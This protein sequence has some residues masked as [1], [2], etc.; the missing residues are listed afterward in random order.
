MQ[1]EPE[2]DKVP[3]RAVVQGRTMLGGPGKFDFDCSEGHILAY[4]LSIYY[5]NFS[6]A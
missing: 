1:V 2:G 5:I 6:A 3:L 4:Y